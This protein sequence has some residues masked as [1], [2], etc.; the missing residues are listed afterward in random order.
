MTVECDPK[1]VEDFALVPV[2]RGPQAGGGGN[3]G[4]LFLKRNLE[5]NV[6]VSF[7]REKVIDDREVGG[8]LVNSMHPLTL[9]DGRKVEQRGEGS[10]H[11][12]VQVRD[13]G[14]NVVSGH[15]DGGDAVER[16]LHRHIRLVDVLHQ[17]ANDG[18]R[19]R[20]S[21]SPVLV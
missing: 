4:A 1:H 18:R 12:M 14:E 2:G 7:K 21:I 6:L 19:T 16:L 20:H 9:V 5:T 3:P 15:P 8:R 10:T 11:R 17:L 13:R